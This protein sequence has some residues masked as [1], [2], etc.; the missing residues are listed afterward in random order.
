MDH[1]FP[2]L[3]FTGKFLTHNW[4]VPYQRVFMIF[5]NHGINRNN[6]WIDLRK[7]T[8]LLMREV[9][10]TFV[11]FANVLLTNRV[12]CP[13][14][15]VFFANYLFCQFAKVFHRQCFPL[16]GSV[17]LFNLNSCHDYKLLAVV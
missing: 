12:L 15:K 8:E 11:T 9:I 2:R 7:L 16:H 17:S 4:I 14:T 13:F 1:G 5:T 10:K 3:A 6:L